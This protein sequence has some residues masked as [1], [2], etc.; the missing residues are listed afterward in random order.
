MYSPWKLFRCSCW[1]T[2]AW[3]PQNSGGALQCLFPCWFLL[4]SRGHFHNDHSPSALLF[5]Q[6]SQ[7]LEQR[8]FSPKEASKT[9]RLKDGHSKTGRVFIAFCVM[10][11]EMTTEHPHLG[12]QKNEA[13]KQQERSSALGPCT[14]AKDTAWASLFKWRAGPESFPLTTQVKDPCHPPPSPLTASPPRPS[15]YRTAREQTK[16]NNLTAVN[17]MA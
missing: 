3:L 17:T 7:L 12:H 15:Q 10:S 16:Y 5:S 6:A 8:G 1:P 11:E 14:L 2:Q 13:R 4:G 9:H